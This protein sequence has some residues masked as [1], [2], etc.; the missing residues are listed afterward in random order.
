MRVA[1]VGK[2]KAGKSSLMNALLGAKV[3]PTG[4]SEL[5]FNV[6]RFCFSET[7][8]VRV[9]FR[10]GR[11]EERDFAD[12][13]KVTARNG[14]LGDYLRSIQHVEVGFPNPMLRQFDI[15]D[16]PG[17]ESVYEVDSENALRAIGLRSA[18]VADWSKSAAARADAILYLFSKSLGQNDIDVLTRF[19]GDL[20]RLTPVNAIGVLT[21]MDDYFPGDANVHRSAEHVIERLK[22]DH[23]VLNQSFYLLQPIS[24]LLGLGAQQLTD[25][26]LKILLRLAAVAESQMEREVWS[27]DG[28]QFRSRAYQQI[29][30]LPSPAERTVVAD[31]LSYYGCRAAV[32]AIRSGTNSLEPLRKFLFRTSGIKTL[33]EVI[34]AHFGNRALAI[35]IHRRLDDLIHYRFQSEFHAAS[36]ASQTCVDK[37]AELCSRFRASSVFMQELDLL[38]RYYEGK[39]GL[40]EEESRRMLEITGED[41]PKA[42]QRLGFDIEVT[43]SEMR[44]TAQR[45]MVYFQNEAYGAVLDRTRR[46]GAGK[47]AELYRSLL[48]DVARAEELLDRESR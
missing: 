17:L 45:R 3:V 23:P 13:Y 11:S 21:R 40:S 4:A 30:G 7:P 42:F 34:L 2:I 35:K 43:I 47:L 12:L 14:A 18:E 6:N 25:E 15:L 19:R 26:E 48:H 22:G 27:R 5:T 24:S 31:R 36:K 33:R 8:Y 20:Q 38:R 44:E 37:V 10:N 39:L 16:T 32:D 29:D 41:G 28:Q 1:I 46:E 9:V